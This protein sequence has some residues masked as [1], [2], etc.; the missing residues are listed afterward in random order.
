MCGN[1]RRSW[2][3]CFTQFPESTLVVFRKAFS[4]GASVV[5][6]NVHMSSDGVRV[7]HDET[8][9]KTTNRHGLVSDTTFQVLRKYDADV[10][11]SSAYRREKIPSLCTST[12]GEKF[13]LS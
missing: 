12:G 8:I 1:Y 11:F 6:I 4:L 10:K 5:E 2:D 9:D 13:L 3:S 7:I